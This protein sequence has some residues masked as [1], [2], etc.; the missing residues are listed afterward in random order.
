[1][2]TLWLVCF[3]TVLIGR[4]NCIDYDFLIRPP[5]TAAGFAQMATKYVVRIYHPW[6]E[7]C[8][9]LVELGFWQTHQEHSLELHFGLL[10]AV[11]EIIELVFSTFILTNCVHH[12]SSTTNLNNPK[13]SRILWNI[14]AT[15]CKRM[16]E[17]RCN[18]VGSVYIKT[19]NLN[20]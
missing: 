15:C 7:F 8:W 16:I 13:E 3:G 20:H 4:S 19:S 6:T 17:M 18:N 9:L 11:P 12:I 5:K 1:M 2:F 10:S 14:A